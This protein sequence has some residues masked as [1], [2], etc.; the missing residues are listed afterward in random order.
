[1]IK[2]IVLAGNRNYTRQLETTIK[3]IL[4]HNRDVKIY[5]L[6][7]DIMPDWFRKPR[8]IASML[9][10]EIIDVKL[11]EQTVFQDWKKQAHIS[12]IA[13]ARYFIPDYI[14]E[15]TVLYLDCDLLI[16][17]KLDSLFEQDVREHYIAAIRDANGQGFNTGVLLINNEKWRQEKLKERLIEQSI[18]T[19]KE[20][21]EGR[22][23]HF[24]GDQTIFNQVLQDDWLELGRAYNLQVGHDIVALYNNWQE[25]LAFNDK[26]VVIH[27]TTYRKPWTTLTANR[28]RD[29]WWEFH[30]LE[31]NQI[32]QHH[33]GE[34]ELI[35]PL[36]KEFSCL[37]L[38][39]SQDLEG[40]EELV[41]AL[42]EVVFHIAAWT[43]MGDKL[44]KLAVYNNVRLHPQIVPPVLDKLK[45]S[46]NLYLDIN[47][48]SA[49]ENFL[50]SLQ[51]QEKTLLAF[52]STQHGELG[53]I[54]FENGKVSFMIDTIKDFKKNGHLTCFRQLPSLTC[55]TFTAS[56]DIEQLDYLAGQLPNVVFQ[57]A[58]WTAMGPKLYDLSNRYP[59]IQLYPAIS[60]DKLDELKE[61]MDAYLDINLLTSTSDIVAEMAHLSKPILAF[62]KSQNGN[63]GQRLYSSEHPERML[64]DLQKLIT[65]DMLEK[66]LDIIQV[67]GIDETLDYIIEHNSSLV[68][69]GDGEVNLMWGL[70]IPYQNHDLELANQLKHI[71]G[72]ESD[73]KLVVCLPDA[74]DDRFVFTWWAT[75]FWKEH[76]NVY[77][78]FYKEL[79]KGSWYGST[80]ISRP[81]IDYEDKSKAKGQFEK[82]KSIWENRDILIVEGI[83]SRSGVGN[84][85]FDKV[86]SVKRIICPSHNAYSVVDN[87]QEEIMK[88]AEGRL[89]LCMLG[90]TAKVL[91]YHL[92]R[93]GYQVLD[94]GHIDSEYEW[95]KMGAKTKVKFSHKHTAEYNFDQDI[96]FIE[97]ETYNS[98]ILVDLSKREV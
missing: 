34:F 74:F 62:Y 75:P 59:N 85:L 64:A 82:L 56:Q 26:P 89:I 96:Q 63:N 45:K 38:T 92:S 67:K 83:T 4:Y 39:N 35:S 69:F 51:E 43:D 9:G 71:V 46:T 57:V 86:K 21:E 95:M 25:H 47:H 8:K 55:L 76:M 90:P 81:Y 22:F 33:L 6:N 60:R 68:R 52:Q 53:Q 31:W 91:A 79:C 30:D 48:G 87:I 32:L 93:K 66:P 2:T 73:E 14:Q 84:D 27:F 3:S 77:M 72:L 37:T 18:V 78:D 24:N 98:Q 13:Y 5:I 94:I 29:L 28:Y 50:K 54:V 70:P 97:D 80:F 15:D 88:H 58:A 49:D 42:P 16:N 61:K 19:M 23:E 10:S 7:Q 40:I 11:P 20:V 44:K 65:K 36:D 41:T 12:S 17:D 1:M